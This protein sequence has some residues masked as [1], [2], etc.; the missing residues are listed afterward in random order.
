MSAKY[1]RYFELL[2]VGPD[3]SADEIRAAYRSAAKKHHPDL[4]TGDR[5]E[6]E[7]LFMQLNDA[8]QTLVDRAERRANLKRASARRGL[9]PQQLAGQDGPGADDSA[10]ELE[11]GLIGLLAHLLGMPARRIRLLL[12]IGGA[13]LAVIVLAFGAAALWRGI[14]PGPG[15]NPGGPP[16]EI[17]LPLGDGVTMTLRLVRPGRFRT[18]ADAGGKALRTVVVDKPFYLGRTEV[19]QAQWQAVMSSSPW[20][21]PEG[22]A[23]IREGPEF[24]ATYVK[25]SQLKQFCESMSVIANRTVYLPTEA[26]WELAC[27]A[28]SQGAY[29]FGDDANQLGAHAWWRQ[30]T[31][32]AGEAYAHPVGAKAPNAWGLHDMHGNVWEWTA[33]RGTSMD[34]GQ[35]AIA[36]GGAWSAGARL[37]RSDAR[38]SCSLNGMNYDIGF[39]VAVKIE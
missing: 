28:G 12:A 37:C 27:R 35:D 31:T 29:S 1:E 26:E 39:R 34:Y 24:P 19:T 16:A 7:R 13:V 25:W 2:D 22:Q 15:A 21:D 11:S 17:T 14:A 30:N 6:A 4:A 33:D 10:A 9:S 36:R 3:A 23:S 38:F 8:Y 18:G 5:G 20:K 32:G